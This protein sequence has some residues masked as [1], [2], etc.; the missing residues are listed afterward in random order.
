MIHVYGL[1]LQYSVEKKA[2]AAGLGFYINLGIKYGGDGL[3]C[4][5]DEIGLSLG[6]NF[7]G[8]ADVDLETW[9]GSVDVLTGNVDSDLRMSY[10]SGSV[11]IKGTI[12]VDYDILGFSGDYDLSI[13]H[14]DECEPWEGCREG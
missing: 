13:S 2:S 3:I 10:H 6:A 4:Y 9:F 14:P 11:C 7:K 5:T 1:P 8:W 12:D